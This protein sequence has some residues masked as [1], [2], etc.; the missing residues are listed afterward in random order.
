MLNPLYSDST[1]ITV[2]EDNYSVCEIEA[3]IRGIRDARMIIYEGTHERR[4]YVTNRVE[5][6]AKDI[7][8]IY[9]KRRDIEVIYRDLSRGRVRIHLPVEAISTGRCICIMATG[10]VFLEISVI[11]PLN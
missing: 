2:S 8:E 10:R 1:S 7:L 3:K 5:W 6:I 11:G 4:Y 9:L